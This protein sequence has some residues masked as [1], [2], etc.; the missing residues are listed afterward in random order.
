MNDIFFSSET[1]AAYVILGLLGIGIPAA[2]VLIWRFGF[3][4][5]T[6]K[7]AFIGAGMFFLFAIILEQLLHMVML[8][9][10]SGNAV[11]YTIYGA[12]A[13]GIFEETAR[14]ISFRFFMKNSRSMENAVSYGLGH[15]GFEAVYICGITALSVLMMAA[16]VNIVGAAEFI[17]STSGGSEA[18]ATQLE[19]QLTAYAQLTMPAVFMSI[20]E[21]I[22]AIALH[23]SLSV[24]VME[25]VMVKSK[26]WLYPAAILIHALFDVPAALYQ[27]GIIPIWICYIIMTVFTAIWIPIAV[28][29][30]RRLTRG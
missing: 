9:L 14:F 28:S 10:V 16:S 24:L 17:Q 8:P 6:I 18:V 12:L 1:I 7:A 19:Q 22:I 11:F 26:F 23:T 21:R 20:Y 25:A 30:Y 3:K 2:A 13:A 5:G 4:K 15:G 29:E 27:S